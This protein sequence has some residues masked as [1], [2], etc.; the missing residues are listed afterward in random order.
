MID[1]DLP[2]NPTTKK[3][4]SYIMSQ[5]N[6]STAIVVDPKKQYDELQHYIFA[7]QKAI[8]NIAPKY[9]DT[10]RMIRLALGASSRNPRLLQCTPKSWVMALMDC[11]FYGLEPN[12]A[13][14]HVYLVPYLNNKLKPPQY[15]VTCLIGYKGLIALACEHGGLDDVE[16]RIVYANEIAEGRFEETPE[17][18]RCPFKHR[19]YYQPD[20]RGVI[21]GAYAIGWRGID[22]RP[23]FKFVTID[24]IESYRARSQ[25]RDNGPWQTDHEAMCMK[26]AIR[27]MLATAQLKPGSKLGTAL[28]QESA[29]ERDEVLRA[30]DWQVVDEPRKGELAPSRTDHLAQEL[31]KKA[32]K[33]GPV[34]K[35]EPEPEPAPH[36]QHQTHPQAEREQDA[37]PDLFVP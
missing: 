36:T 26:T 16:P 4:A 20:A 10:E 22:K 5:K 30:S 14:G 15:E 34:M 37:Q 9:L 11:A 27:R 7:K 8:A 28:D 6:Q 31:A 35:V 23:R 1:R 18:P 21:A 3:R 13:L 29:L 2:D 12:A 32:G 19:P 17:D 33:T 25:A 24:E